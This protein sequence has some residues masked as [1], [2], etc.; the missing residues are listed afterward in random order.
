LV[1]KIERRGCL[2]DGEYRRVKQALNSGFNDSVSERF[3][4]RQVTCEDNDND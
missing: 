3:D 1:R 2:S 4:L